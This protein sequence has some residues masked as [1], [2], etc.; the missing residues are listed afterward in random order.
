MSLIVTGVNH[1]TAPIEIREKLAFSGS[2]RVPM[3]RALRSRSSR[4]EAALL[5]TCN[6]TEAYLVDS[7]ESSVGT[8]RDIFSDR[9]GEDASP[10][11]YARHDREP[12][13]HLFRVTAGPD[14][15]ILGE[16]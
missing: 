6:R 11:I 14:S 2:D 5:S 8:V 16:A 10:F 4:T 13:A 7:D 15:M 1:R 9:L 12:A 3:L